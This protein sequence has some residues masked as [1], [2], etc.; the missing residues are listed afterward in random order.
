M[1]TLGAIHETVG[2]IAGVVRRVRLASGAARSSEG[3][4]AR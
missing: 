1:R 4:H 2:V 3:G